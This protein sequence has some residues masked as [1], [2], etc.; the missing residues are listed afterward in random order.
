[1]GIA[2]SSFDGECAE[3]LLR[4]ADAA[5]RRAHLDAKSDFHSLLKDQCNFW[6][7]YQAHLEGSLT[8]EVI[9][10]LRSD[11]ME[12]LDSHSDMVIDLSGVECID[13]AGLNL[14]LQIQEKAL[15]VGK[16]IDFIGFNPAIEDALTVFRW[17]AGL[18]RDQRSQ[19]SLNLV[20][21]AA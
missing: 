11:W 1:V 14:M 7:N 12:K 4:N 5:K 2:M 17:L 9:E 15:L 16:H 6:V 19:S 13:L 20:Q 10:D 8:S 18:V 3:E 21:G